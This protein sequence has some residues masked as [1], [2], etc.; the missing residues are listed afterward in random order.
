MSEENN[1]GAHASIRWGD[2]ESPNAAWD[3][4]YQTPVIQIMN[5]SF[6]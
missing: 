6:L 1:D 2:F 4:T 5:L 3:F